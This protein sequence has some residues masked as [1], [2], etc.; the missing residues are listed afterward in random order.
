MGVRMGLVLTFI[1][2]AM[3]IGPPIQ[4]WLMSFGGTFDCSQ[5]DAVLLGASVR[6]TCSN[7]RI[8]LFRVGKTYA[9]GF[10]KSGN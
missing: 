9:G 7:V 3:L 5:P 10:Q 2:A 6:E 8:C 4:G 1:G